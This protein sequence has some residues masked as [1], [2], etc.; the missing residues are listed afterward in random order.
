MTYDLEDVDLPVLSGGALSL[1]AGVTESFAG[2]PVIA[3]LHADGG[4]PKARAAAIL[5]APVT[6]PVWPAGLP[7]A[8]PLPADALS[9]LPHERPRPMALP[10]VRDF[11]ERYASGSLSPEA[12]A[13][14][15]IAGERAID[16]GSHPLRAFVAMDAEDV[17]HQARESALRWKQGRPLSVLDGVPIAIKDELDCV[18]YSTH[19]GTSFLGRAPATTDATVVRRLR[20]LGALLVGKTNMYEI[21][22]NP[23]GF[24]AHFGQARNPHDRMRE[25]GGSS[26]GSAVAVAA[27]LC[28]A[29]I[30]ADGGGS[31]RIPAAWCGLVGLKPTYGRVSEVGAFPL[32]W[33]V[34]HIGPITTSVEDCALVYAAIAGADPSDPNTQ[35]QPPPSI[36][37]AF[38]RDLNGLR[39]GVF[40]PW[41]EHAAP[42]LVAAAKEMRAILEAAGAVVR[43][44]VVPELELER[45]AHS[46]TILTEMAASMRDVEPSPKAHGA[47][48][49]LTLAAARA[50]T[51]T[52]YLWAQRVRA[53]R[54]HQWREIFGSVDVILTPATGGM[55]TPLPEPMPRA[56]WSNLSA[57]IESMRY[58]YAGNLCGLP[59]ISFPSGYD[60]TGLPLAVQVMGRPWE[61]H[62]LLRV[63][64]V[65]EQA[66]ER[67]RPSIFVE[68]T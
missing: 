26:S 49:R 16:R 32:C 33:S 2:G 60:E 22:I 52:D 11:S 20:A 68:V 19:V 65:A 5:E 29:A 13:E 10:R 8:A 3:R 15:V 23:G 46:I 39:I 12:V 34:A 42:A 67:R 55:P 7:H 1:L 61:E 51:G 24:N 62:V 40:T 31:V 53:R 9:A 21:G 38:A 28:P 63:A 45:L 48:V 6:Q 25:S 27:G 14:A 30:G 58:I 36:E 57:T 56:G 47:A 4:I 17:R 43:E 59:A 18:P 54:M 37:G 41:F 66:V 44:V 50:F 64:H 35:A